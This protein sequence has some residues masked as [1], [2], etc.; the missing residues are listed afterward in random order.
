MWLSG[1]NKWR[2][3]AAKNVIN[4]GPKNARNSLT[5]CGGSSFSRDLLHGVRT[6]VMYTV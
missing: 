3:V 4:S 6:T 5:I 1:K 2:A